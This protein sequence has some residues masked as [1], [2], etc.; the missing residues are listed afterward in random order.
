M[1]GS[2][3]PVREIALRHPAPPADLQPLVQIEL[4][5]L[6]NHRRP[7]EEAEIQELIH[8]GIPVPLLQ[9]VVESVV[10]GVE[11][12][13]DADQAQL[14]RDD[15]GEENAAGPA[16]LGPEIRDGKPRDRG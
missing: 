5:D 8:E 1:R 12:D 10:P 4:I 9:R 13:R 2:F 11:Q 3:Q 7:C 15:G 16:I 6:E 14:A